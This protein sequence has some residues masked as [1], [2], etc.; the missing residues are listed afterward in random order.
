MT[1]RVG[2]HNKEM[3]TIVLVV[4]NAW[5]TPEEQNGHCT[6]FLMTEIEVHHALHGKIQSG[7]I[8]LHG[9]E[10]KQ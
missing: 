6:G 3:M 8:R 7:E 2:N 4:C 10:E 5:R 9:H 1:R